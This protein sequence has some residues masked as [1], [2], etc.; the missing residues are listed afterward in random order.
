MKVSHLLLEE[1]IHTYDE[2]REM[3]FLK[4]LAD[5]PANPSARGPESPMVVPPALNH[6]LPRKLG[7]PAMAGRDSG[8]APIQ[9][10]APVLGYH[11]EASDT[12][13][14]P[15]FHFRHLLG[16]TVT[17]TTTIINEKISRVS[18]IWWLFILKYTQCRAKS[19]GSICLLVK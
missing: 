14:R 2:S 18:G 4:W 11:R 15:V 5:V 9:I 19:K 8:T 7:L 1:K 6:S 13:Y 3:Q 16:V 12:K 10:L 17:R